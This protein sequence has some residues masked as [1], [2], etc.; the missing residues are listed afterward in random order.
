MSKEAVLALGRVYSGLGWVCKY[1]LQSHILMEFTAGD[2]W[3]AISLPS[4]RGYIV[5]CVPI[6]HKTLSA[7]A[8]L[9]E[10]ATSPPKVVPMLQSIRS[11]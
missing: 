1:L 3:T 7:D 5:P 2:E 4:S 11:R 10:A 9:A 6:L 8:V